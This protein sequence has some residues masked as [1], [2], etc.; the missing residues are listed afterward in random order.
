MDYYNPIRSHFERIPEEKAV[1]DPKPD[2]SYHSD[3]STE[4]V[5]DDAQR[6]SSPT[7]TDTGV[8]DEVKSSD[9]EGKTAVQPKDEGSRDSNNIE[10]KRDTESETTP[11]AGAP[12]NS[13]KLKKFFGINVPVRRTPTIMSA[14]WDR[15]VQTWAFV[16]SQPIRKSATDFITYAV[17]WT[18]ILFLLYIFITVKIICKLAPRRFT[19]F[20]RRALPEVFNHED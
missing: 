1:D 19:P 14:S 15:A 4:K 9:D 3:Q 11:A 6:S 5:E 10:S 20:T 7:S 16:R 18:V 17:S 2:E 12:Y 13:E 8:E